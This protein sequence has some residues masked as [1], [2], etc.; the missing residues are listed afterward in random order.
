MA[1]AVTSLNHIQE[2]GEFIAETIFLKLGE[3][4]AVHSDI[5]VPDFKI[6][7]FS[8]RGRNVDVALCPSN[9]E[10]SFF[11]DAD[12]DIGRCGCCFIKEQSPGEESFY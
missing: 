9:A 3:Y 7:G 1:N 10:V 11:F 2:G 6:F 8:P 4:F 5:F 12:A